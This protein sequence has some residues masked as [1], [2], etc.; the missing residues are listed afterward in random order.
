MDIARKLSNR[1]DST[2]LESEKASMLPST[3]LRTEC[4]VER[5]GIS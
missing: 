4:K 2:P 5:K 3:L 1:F